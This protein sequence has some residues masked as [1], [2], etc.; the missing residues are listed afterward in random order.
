MWWIWLGAA[1]SAQG[2]DLD[3]WLQIGPATFTGAG[4]GDDVATDVAIDRT[5]HVIA[6]GAIDGPPGHGTNG[7]VVALEYYDLGFMWD[8]EF[9]AGAVGDGVV[10]SD[11]RIEAIANPGT[12]DLAFCGRMASAQ[13][14]PSTVPGGYWVHATTP[15]VYGI[16]YTPSDAWSWTRRDGKGSEEQ[17]CLD[18]DRAGQRLFAAGY[19]SHVADG[20]RWVS[21]RADATTGKTE[22]AFTASDGVGSADERAHGISGGRKTGAFAV[23]GTLAAPAGDLD[24]HVRFHDTSGALVWQDRVSGAVGRD[25]VAA[26]VV[27]DEDAGTV[28]V[29]GT[30]A[31]NPK[32]GELDWRIVQYAA[33]G[34]G[35]GGPLV[36]WSASVGHDSGTDDVATAIALD[37]TGAVI[38]G[39][40]RVVGGREVWHVATFDG[41]TGTPAT[42]W[43]GPTYPADTRILGMHYR[44]RKLA[45]AGYAHDGDG[46]TFTVAALEP[47]SDGD[48]VSDS[49]DEC[50]DDAE[51][52]E[53]GICGCGV[54]DAD[55]RDGD[56]TPDCIDRCPDDP[57][58]SIREGYCGCGSPDV[59]S[60]GDA[61]L[62]CFDACPADGAKVEPGPCGCGVADD[63][64]DRDGVVDCADACP[65]SS[66]GAA[67]DA[68]GCA[69][70]PPRTGCAH[71]PPPGPALPM[72]ILGLGL[73][74]RR[75]H[76]RGCHPGFSH[77]EQNR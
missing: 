57:D 68:E 63:D 22:P 77:R 42:T 60:D 72:W 30:I 1:A 70:E 13:I 49:P 9:D 69:E 39:G 75:R 23:V 54:S 12:N 27:Y 7:Y 20:G 74:V 53:S 4:D 35:A 45:L 24:W 40:G 14:G 32:T 51:K 73:L 61:V 62:D 37:E 41:A 36:N 55:D 18:L 67:V 17:A 19:S 76:V 46:R 64:R 2:I 11:D 34:D 65:D 28:S 33:S 5:G 10:D 15:D 16:H 29:A 26:A 38:A 21:F 71:L 59:D 50:P 56:E 3:A 43:T 47:D 58:K 52:V 8:L 31:T 48:G 44:D 6:V 66:A 25:D